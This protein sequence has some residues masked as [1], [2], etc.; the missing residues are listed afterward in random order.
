[1]MHA[2]VDMYL[3]TCN[4]FGRTFNPD[5]DSSKDKR[6]QIIHFITVEIKYRLS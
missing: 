2:C 5:K 3:L 1:M 4:V 6:L